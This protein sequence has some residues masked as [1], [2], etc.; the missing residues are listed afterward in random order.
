KIQVVEDGD[1]LAPL[2][3][4]LAQGGETNHRSVRCQLFFS[5]E[6]WARQFAAAD[7]LG[8]APAVAPAPSSRKVTFT[9]MSGRMRGSLCLNPMRTFT[10]AFSRLAVGTMAITEAGM[11]QSG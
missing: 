9:A 11:F 3:E 2:G 10:V 6:D 1:P 8:R 4:A 5:L 7:S